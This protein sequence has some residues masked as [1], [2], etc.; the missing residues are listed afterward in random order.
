MHSN[1]AQCIFFKP[2]IEVFNSYSQIVYKYMYSMTMIHITKARVH[3]TDTH[4]EKLVH[5]LGAFYK[6][7]NLQ[8]YM[9]L[10]KSVKE[11]CE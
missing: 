2:K 3:V 1:N 11:N 7:Y 4:K 9:Y 8:Y 6:C 10:S 5:S